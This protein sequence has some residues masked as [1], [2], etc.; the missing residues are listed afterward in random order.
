MQIAD[1]NVESS[2]KQDFLGKSSPFFHN[3]GLSVFFKQL[4]AFYFHFEY[5]KSVCYSDKT[6]PTV[7]KAK[8]RTRMLHDVVR[9]RE[10]ALRDVAPAIQLCATSRLRNIP[11]AM[12]M[13]NDAP[14]ASLRHAKAS[15]YM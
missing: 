14:R 1:K 3:S 13:N 5:F 6:K 11:L 9:A 15:L 12:A 8:R 10:L 7:L 4:K 2:S